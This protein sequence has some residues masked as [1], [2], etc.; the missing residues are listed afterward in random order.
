MVDANTH[1]PRILDLESS[2]YH[3]YQLVITENTRMTCDVTS[4]PT[5]SLSIVTAGDRGRGRSVES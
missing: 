5:E 2:H 4:L 3:N 1:L